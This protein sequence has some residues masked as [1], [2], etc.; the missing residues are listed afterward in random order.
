MMW[1]GKERKGKER[2]GKERKDH[3]VVAYGRCC[4]QLSPMGQNRTLL[5]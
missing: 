2:K 3:A 5:S 4:T 1:M